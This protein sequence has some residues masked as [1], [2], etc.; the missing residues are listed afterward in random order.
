MVS[1]SGNGLHTNADAWR[2][3]SDERM[4]L[5]SVGWNLRTQR[6]V[7][8]SRFTKGYF[9]RLV[10]FFSVDYLKKKNTKFLKNERTRE[11]CPTSNCPHHKSTAELPGSKIRSRY[12]SQALTDSAS[13]H[14]IHAYKKN[15]FT[16]SQSPYCQQQPDIPQ[17][18][19]HRHPHL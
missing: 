5:K 15:I 2:Y 6:K 8:N 13:N 16:T 1:H 12:T 17:N 4:S 18:P 11:R 7:E 9:V 19:T 3:H 10:F 14:Q